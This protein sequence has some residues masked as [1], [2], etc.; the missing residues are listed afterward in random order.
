MSNSVGSFEVQLRGQ[1]VWYGTL[2][3]LYLSGGEL[4]MLWVLEGLAH[5]PGLRI[6]GATCLIRQP[7]LICSK[8]Y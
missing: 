8:N 6:P 3:C 1:V 5:G 7:L 2:P 4:G